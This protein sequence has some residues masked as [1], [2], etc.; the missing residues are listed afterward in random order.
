MRTPARGRFGYVPT[1][2]DAAE[3]STL[4]NSYGMLR[5]PWNNDPTPFL[6]RSDHL[7]GY[8]NHRKPSGCRKY[9]AA[10]KQRT[11]MALTNSF[12]DGAHGEIHELLGG[13]WS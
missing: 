9:R 10:K 1:M 4:H 8:M 2:L 6:T 3:Y 12:N 11:W 13:A 7:L 5:S